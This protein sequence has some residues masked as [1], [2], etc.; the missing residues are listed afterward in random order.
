V[1]IIRPLVSALLLLGLAATARAATLDDRLA[2]LKED[3]TAAGESTVLDLLRDGMRQKRC[4]EVMAALGPWL[5]QNSL[6]NP[7]AIYL[8][9]ASADLAGDWNDA[10][11]FYRKLLGRQTL[12]ARLTAK[13]VPAFYRLLVDGV[14]DEQAAYLYMRKNGNRLRGYGDARKFDPW[15]LEQA[16]QRKDVAATA[17]RL[18]AIY[19]AGDADLSY[20]LRF[21]DRLVS[22]IETFN[23]KD[24]DTFP[25]LLRLADAR[26]V[27]EE[28]GATIR[29]IV[30]VIPLNEEIWKTMR[31]RKTVPPHRFDSAVARAE[32]LVAASPFQGSITALRGWGN[33]HEGDTPR[34]LKYTTS[35]GERKFKPILKVLADLPVHQARTVLNT[36]LARGRSLSGVIGPGKLRMLAMDRPAIFN[37]FLAPDVSLLWREITQADAKALAPL[38]TRNPHR[39]AAAVRAIAK[40]G[41]RLTAATDAMIETEA[42]R[43][44]WR[45]MEYALKELDHYVK[46]DTDF[47]KLLR[48]AKEVSLPKDWFKKN[49]GK[50]VSERD[51]RAEIDRLTRDLTSK[52]P[53]IKGALHLFQEFVN[54]GPNDLRGE[55]FARMLLGKSDAERDLITRALLESRGIFHP[56]PGVVGGYVQPNHRWG[57][58][59]RFTGLVTQLGRRLESDLK[60]GRIS[61]E[62][63]GWYMNFTDIRKAE[64][65]KLIRRVRLSPVYHKVARHIRENLRR[66]DYFGPE[67]GPTSSRGPSEE[68]LKL[69]KNAKIGQVKSALNTAIADL[70]KAEGLPGVYGLEAVAAYPD[71]WR[72][73]LDE[74]FI[75][76]VPL[77]KFRDHLGQYH[78]VFRPYQTI[79]QQYTA[80]LRK[81]R[82]Y[83]AILPYIRPF[84]AATQLHYG[85]HLGNELIKLTEEALAAGEVSTAASLARIGLNFCPANSRHHHEK[86]NRVALMRLGAKASAALGIAEIPVAAD[87]PGFKIFKSQ[88]EFVKG[89]LDAAWSLYDENADQIEPM[90]RRLR[91]DYCFWTLGMN[92]KKENVARVETLVKLLTLWDRR[93]NAAFTLQQQAELKL[94]YADVAFLKRATGT[95]RAWYRKVADAAEFKGSPQQYRAVLGSVAVDRHEKNYAGALAELDRLMLVRDEALRQK[96]HFA[97]ARIFYDQEKYADADEEIAAVLRQNP[98]HADALILMGKVLNRKREFESATDLEIGMGRSQKIIVPGEMIKINLSDPSLNVTG[99]TA[100]IE[101]EVRAASGDVERVML[102]P[103]G[104]GKT[105]YRA[106]IPSGLGSPKRGDKVLQVLGRDTI[107]YGYSERFRQRMKDLPPDPDEKI[108]IAADFRLAISAGDFP[109]REGERRLSVE[110][111]GLSTAEQALGRGRVRP[112][113]PIYI[114]VIDAD[115]S[116]TAGIDEV[117]VEI[118][119]SS[120][121]I[122]KSYALKET[123]PFSGEF[124]G[125]V[126]TVRGQAAAFA[127]SADPGR[128]PNMAISAADYPGWAAQASAGEGTDS[129]G[130]DLN[131]NVELGRMT[132][133]SPDEQA[134]EHF[135]VQTSMNGTDW[136]SRAS[137]PEAVTPWDC[138]PQI[139]LVSTYGRGP[140]IPSP[141]DS[142]LPKAWVE[143]MDNGSASP[144]IGY[145][146]MTVSNLQGIRVP[147][148]SGHPGYSILMHFKACFYQPE[149]AQRRFKL[150]APKGL[151]HFVFL[152]N[153]KTAG[154]SKHEDVDPSLIEMDLKPGLHTIEVWRNANCGDLMKMQIL[155]DD[156]GGKLIPCPDSM[157]DP[158]MFP[159]AIRSQLPQPTAIEFV[160]G[161]YEVNF[162]RHTHAQLVRLLIGGHA[163]P[164][165]AIKKLTLSCADG[166]SCLPVKSDYQKLRENDELEVLPG[167]QVFVKYVDDMPATETRTQQQQRLVV[168]YNTA[169]IS[170]SFLTYRQ[171][172][173]RRQLVLEPIRRFRMDDNVAFVI[174]D[175][176]MDVSP[177]RDVVDFKVRTSDGNTRDFK[178]YETEVHSG[179]FLGKV[180]PV[181]TR[182]TRASEIRMTEGGT[183]TAVY[184]DE[185]NLDPGIPADRTVTVEH[186][187]YSTPRFGVFTSRALP[188]EDS[189]TAGAGLRGGKSR[190]DNSRRDAEVFVP[191]ISLGADY[192]AQDELAQ[193][194]LTAILNS[195]ICFDVV[196]PHLA[197][198]R[199]SEISAYV[200]TESSR[201]MYREQQERMRAEGGT[202]PPTSPVFDVN[203]PG[204]MKLSARPGRSRGLAIP[205]GYVAGDIHA[206]VSTRSPLDEGRFTFNLDLELGDLPVQSYANEAAE[207]IPA[208]LLPKNLVVRPG[209]TIHIG[210]AYLDRDG[211]PNWHTAKLEVSGHVFLDVMNKDYSETCTSRYI[212]QK[213]YVRVI[214]PILD[215]TDGRD[216]VDVE[217]A[218]ASGSRFTFSVRESFEHTGVFKGNFKLSYSSKPAGI[219]DPNRFFLYGLP[220]RYGDSVKVKRAESYPDAYEVAI[221]RGAD[222]IVVPFSKRYGDSSVAVRTN[223]TLAECFFELAKQHKKMEREDLSRREMDHA[224]KL[225]EEALASHRDPDLQA[226]AEYLLGNLAQ[227]YADLAKNAESKEKGYRQAL[228]RFSKIPE[229]YPESMFAAKAQFKKALVYEKMEQMHI[230]VEEYV[231]LVYKY[232]DDERIPMAM[233]RLGAYFQKRGIATKKRADEFLANDN[234][235]SQ[236]E[237]IKLMDKANEDF[238]RAAKVFKKLH[239]RFP[240]DP[241]AS[242]AGVRA[243]Q[244]LMRLGAFDDAC[245]VFETVYD[246]DKFDGRT[247]RAQA[248][249]WSGLSHEKA[250][251]EAEEGDYRT[252]GSHI[253]S[254]YKLYNRTRFDYPDSKWA[255]YA[256]GRLTDKV[257]ARLIEIDREMRERQLEGMKTR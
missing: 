244:N 247:I 30:E 88:A 148:V 169:E 139:S 100:A 137:H 150:T 223:F 116:R 4:A 214:A 6:E 56:M 40:G 162:G 46:R 186:A 25:S 37:S 74:L 49:F 218:S 255:K 232:P 73:R 122:I 109:P 92:V 32:E 97:R 226:Q 160:D 13:A 132:I 200:Q 201:R 178:A 123:R 79:A 234:Q 57:L 45:G 15:F 207:S 213:I 180:F 205:K 89:N 96:V 184:R 155:C 67:P 170:V 36:R 65:Q 102:R 72:D 221:N 198:T 43:F 175:A 231:K 117:S 211:K 199:N 254:A 237:A 53:S 99:A 210:Y 66:P 154:A 20:Y 197:F 249:Y 31:A 26:G 50:H 238:G 225:L 124:E 47:G 107:T 86:N 188:L 91:H 78:N 104:D 28:V 250:A 144:K 42:W 16:L 194:P 69:G 23:C 216:N 152:L 68:L 35:E 239:K 63:L 29:F 3:S 44:D 196:A 24:E 48:R 55:T 22:E 206:P 17:E 156:N 112:G 10:R 158:S 257:F 191:R 167:D 233:S 87:E 242:M 202:P 94:A 54:R 138:S 118:S 133:T 90:I 236:E 166:R 240:T 64:V 187:R 245:A 135:V 181:T 131:D 80:D 136:V 230:A 5:Q 84:W 203:V 224:K 208:G 171:A 39:Y 228:A 58:H 83:N 215:T 248:L 108:G 212:G 256:R 121:D 220:V 195:S 111:L 33:I 27:P 189:V 241:L 128:D 149:P 151:G 1:K 11:S 127:S 115:Q 179:V 2:K 81:T 12:D 252:R 76:Y 219:V 143:A 145:E 129:F 126:L 101:V 95:A 253:G 193:A 38:L 134:L 130:V 105:K 146:S 159:E 251:A 59:G 41:K 235:K 209:D 164:A 165:P 77:G 106:E 8:A 140:Q 222:G 147:H 82:N 182:P 142:S 61:D 120:G 114:R 243:G 14:R 85:G 157:F 183:L 177:R 185:E 113:N 153:G 217:L 125:S 7:E 163:G 227:E 168:A 204:T 119:T 9:A 75:E 173:E 71:V 229:D 52:S 60:R 174:K 62:V 51:R 34:F 110:E 103:L 21:V 172:G 18:A 176:D 161:A 190:R 19:N 141:E 192:V 98:N 70:K 246:N 93:G